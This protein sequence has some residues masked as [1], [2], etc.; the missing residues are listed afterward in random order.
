MAERSYFARRGALLNRTVL[1]LM[2]AGAAASY[3]VASVG[4]A[5]GDPRLR[6]GFL[7]AAALPAL[8]ALLL[9][10]A[11]FVEPS[12]I[13]VTRRR[14]RLGTKKPL[15][16]VVVGDF[17]VGP[18]KRAKFVERAVKKINSLG[19]DIVL[20]VGDFLFDH[21]ADLRHLRPLR[22]LRPALGTFAVV[23][24]HDSGA[25][26]TF[27]RGHDPRHDRCDDLAAYLEECGVRC[28]RN[29]STAVAFAGGT[30]A[31]AGIDDLWMPS[32]D[33]GAAFADVPT[34]AP[35]ILLSH[36]PDVILDPA[37]HRATLI[38]SGHTHGGQVR[39][40]FHGSLTRLPQKLSKKFDRGI[41]PVAAGCT[42]AITH[43]IGESFLPLRLFAHPEILLLDAR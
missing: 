8:A 18:Y 39:L 32:C 11:R 30:V 2:A 38:V 3:G 5:F 9:F 13:V 35:C 4:E 26:G 20:L 43:G 14:V 31:V 40:P 34:D 36:N 12:L 17:H 22:T 23:G 16:V 25:H 15:R 37:S 19:P 27:A 24:N 29:A 6:V 7:A 21:D 10:Y 28:L 41:F 33:L 42:L 1:V